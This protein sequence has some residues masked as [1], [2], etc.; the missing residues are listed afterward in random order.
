M[1]TSIPL[2]D[3]H[4]EA[5]RYAI[6]RVRVAHEDHPYGQA[7]TEVMERLADSRKAEQ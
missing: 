4:I 5:I 7:F 1:S 2:S 3:E 6:T